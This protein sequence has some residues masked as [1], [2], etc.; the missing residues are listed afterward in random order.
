[1]STTTRAAA[2]TLP[3]VTPAPATLGAAGALLW[4]SILDQFELEQFEQSLL[5]QACRCADRLDELAAAATEPVVTNVKGDITPHPALVES[6]AQALV[7]AR[8]L[9]SLRLPSGETAD[10]SLVR[11][12]RRGAARGTYQGRRQS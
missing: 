1:M 2:L 4:S 5:L 7:L 6:R 12:Q 11:P 9:A 8:M 10:G 3:P